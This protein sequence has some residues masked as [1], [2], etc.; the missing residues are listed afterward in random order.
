[1]PQVTKVQTP[2]IT[3]S[4]VEM[5]FIKPTVTNADWENAYASGLLK[6]LPSQQVAR[7]RLHRQQFLDMAKKDAEF[8]AK[9]SSSNP[10]VLSKAHRD[11]LENVDKSIKSL[12]TYIYKL[13]QNTAQQP[14]VAVEQQSTVAVEQQPIV[15]VEQQP[16]VDGSLTT[17]DQSSTKIKHIALY[18]ILGF[19]II[20]GF[21]YY[22]T[23]HTQP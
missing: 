21:I 17:E 20:G 1:M 22:K 23:K 5:S 4:V 14:I 8:R 19:A 10:N 3:L 6:N 7:L 18:S 13:S 15:A 12:E 9:F 16:I 11:Y 2:K